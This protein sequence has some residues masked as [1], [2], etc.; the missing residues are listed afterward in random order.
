MKQGLVRLLAIV[1]WALPAF[2]AAETEVPYASDLQRDGELARQKQAIIL[3]M[4]SNEFCPYC[5]VVLN[6]FL[7]PMSRNPD[8][9][10]K[11]VMRRVENTGDLPLKGFDGRVQTHRQFTK[12][13]GVRLVP[14]VMLLDAQGRPLG[15]P[16]IGITTVDYYGY[17]LDQAIDQGLARVRN[18]KTNNGR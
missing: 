8:Y 9:Q 15:K 3:V 2:V 17:Y 14:T 6:E 11:L 12:D 18:G 16:L 10:K 5:E 7:N 1:A 13:L 4:F